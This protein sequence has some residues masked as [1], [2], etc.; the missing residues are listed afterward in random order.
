MHRREASKPVR[1]AMEQG[2]ISPDVSVFDYGCGHGADVGHLLE[3][4]VSCS[5]WDP[6]HRPGNPIHEADVVN[7]GYVVNVIE[8]VAERAD[9]LRRAWAL[10][11]R[12]LLVSGRLVHERRLLTGQECEDGVVTA[13][14]TFQKFFEQNELRLWIE[15]ILGTE[16]V[17]AAP[18][19]F[20]VFRSAMDREA[21]LASRF[22]RCVAL[23]R[24][25]RSES[26]YREHEEMLAPLLA[27]MEERGRPPGD[28]ELPI[29]AELL[30]SFGSMRRALLVLTRV[31][32]S[33]H[34][35]QTAKARSEDLM[36][37]LALSRFGGRPRASDLPVAIRNDVRFHCGSYTKACEQ[38]DRL[39]YS[40]GHRQTLE[41]AMATSEIGKLTP[42][43]LYIHV[44]HLA[45]LDAVLRVYEG[46]ARALV[47]EVPGANVLKL[48]REKFQVSYLTYPDFDSDPHPRLDHSVVVKLQALDVKYRFFDESPNPPVLHR[49]ETLLAATDNRYPKFRRLTKQEERL[50]LLDATSDIG[51]VAGWN[52]RLRSKGVRL[53]G[54]RV[55]RVTGAASAS[56]ETETR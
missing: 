11:R 23:P 18:G 5:G 20:L 44:D 21:F 41:E 54:H 50:G 29:E 42:S 6:V 52:E 22:R 2:L 39:L 46:C 19:I 43:A 1:L 26:L 35:N 14:G 15:G 34:W 49:K 3:V 31:F 27:F 56:L 32:G 40:A 37:Y 17:P 10:A 12:L 48:S 51:T 53:S 25:R 4:G 47:G 55:V 16:A 38:G 30:S 13:R 8:S 7:L 36:V 24:L 28:Q 33:D 9:T 45:C